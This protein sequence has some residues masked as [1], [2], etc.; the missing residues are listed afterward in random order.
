V[1]HLDRSLALQP[2]A[3]CVDAN[4]SNHMPCCTRE[5]PQMKARGH[6]QCLCCVIHALTKDQSC[7]CMGKSFAICASCGYM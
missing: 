2:V 1:S 6:M 3:A 4:S 7:V 5:L